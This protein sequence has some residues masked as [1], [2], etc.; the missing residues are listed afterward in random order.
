M[1]NLNENFPIANETEYHI[2]LNE[3]EA[4]LRQ[5][6]NELQAERAEIDQLL[7]S[8]SMM[9]RKKDL[10]IYLIVVFITGSMLTMGVMIL[11]SLL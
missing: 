5:M 10:H 4:Q 11:G 1:D 8:E 7:L 9:I 2:A 3:K 6:K